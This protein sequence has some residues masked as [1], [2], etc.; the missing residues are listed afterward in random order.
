MVMTMVSLF[1]KAIN[2]VAMNE[3]IRSCLARIHDF[4]LMDDEERK[5]YTKRQRNFARLVISYYV[6]CYVTTIALGINAAFQRTLVFPGSY[7]CD[8]RQGGACYWSVYAYQEIGIGLCMHLNVSLQQISCF[9]MYEMSVQLEILGNR[10]MQI[11][12]KNRRNDRK[13]VTLNNW[14]KAH[15]QSMQ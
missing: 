12:W 7:P 3:S 11:G 2:F 8:W 10:L 4:G 6:V 15:T 1:V 14:V 13:Y 9:M 5:L